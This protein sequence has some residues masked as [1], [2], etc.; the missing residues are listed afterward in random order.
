[1][2]RVLSN[3]DRRVGLIEAS[4]VADLVER[5]AAMWNHDAVA[6]P[7][8]RDTYPEFAARVD[9]FARGLL[10]LGLERG[11]KVGL[12]LPQGLD[13]LAGVFGAAKVGGVAVPI[14]ARFKARELAYL[15]RNSDMRVLFT[16][17]DAAEFVDW[18]ALLEESL[19]SLAE[20]TSP[21]LTLEEAP[22][23][24]NVVV[25]GPIGDRPWH[26]SR[27]AFD[28]GAESADPAVVEARRYLNRIR[29]TAIIMYTSGTTAFPKGA[30]LSHEALVRHGFNVART[31]FKIT[32]GEKVWAPLPLYHI[33]GIAFAFACFAAGAT[34]VHSSFFDP[35]TS[36]KQLREEKPVV[37]IPTFE[38]I[39]MSILNHPDFDP[40]DFSSL[41]LVFNVGNPVRLREQQER[42]PNAPQ[43]SGY[44]S[45][46]ASSF[47]TMGESE[48][49]VDE[50]VEKLGR[51][52]P[53]IELR[54]VDPETNEPLPPGEVGE[55]VYRGYS[56][57]DGY[58]NDP[59][60]TAEAFDEDGWFHSG[61]LGM[62]DEDHR[63][64]FVSRLKDMMKVGGENVAAAEVEA[65]L[66][67]HPAVL[68]AQVVAAPDS[69]YGE[70]PAA[71]IQLAGGSTAT[72]EE[73]IDYCRGTIA[74]FKVPRYVRFVDEYPMSGTKIQKFVLRERITAELAERGITEAPR[75][76]SS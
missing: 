44:G 31:R 68:F 4:T 12:L 72:E 62:M 59:E 25:F 52:L 28:A 20:Q 2:T 66:V 36:I 33:G 43:V 1:M 17:A 3:A 67:T 5:G 51:P 54:V 47:L 45:T 24:R 18:P 19:P 37:A 65:Y 6:F 16:S 55:F 76:T 30:M 50:R 48:D 41:R 21:D 29:D 49:P 60:K 69:R 26:V 75:I 14:N 39:W 63:S 53:G 9:H 13:Y 11:D 57:C 74:T 15:V 34:Y 70:V 27:E 61:D 40:A 56:V 38:T 58:Y 32:A 8:E 10:A 73:L 46:E 64:T 71:F 23:L 7:H 22:D 42:L 35:E